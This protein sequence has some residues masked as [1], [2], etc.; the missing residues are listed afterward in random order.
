MCRAPPPSFFFLISYPLAVMNRQFILSFHELSS[1]FAIFSRRR[2]RRGGVSQLPT[3][4][5]HEGNARCRGRAPLAGQTVAKKALVVAPKI[6]KCLHRAPLRRSYRVRVFPW[7]NPFCPNVPAVQR[8]RS[9][10]CITGGRP[11]YSYDGLVH[12]TNDSFCSGLGALLAP[13]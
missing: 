7:S 5:V 4:G 8:A 3:P 13:C 6:N 9:L 1:A 10:L 11:L 12:Q 2:R